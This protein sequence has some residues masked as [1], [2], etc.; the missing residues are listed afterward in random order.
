MDKQFDDEITKIVHGFMQVWNRY[1]VTLSKELSQIQQSLQEMHPDR[2]SHPNTNYELFYRAC[3]SIYP[4][5]DI[6]MHEFS[7]ALAVPLSTATRIAD[8]L[9]E[10]QYIERLQDPGDR[11]VVRIKLTKNGKTLYQ[12]IDQYIRQRAQQI[13]A[14]LTEKERSNLITLIGKVVDGLNTL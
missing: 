8:W 11:R 1:E 10:N 14:N 2:V 4:D 12:S 13:L 5:G 7:D 3:D 6:T 9:V